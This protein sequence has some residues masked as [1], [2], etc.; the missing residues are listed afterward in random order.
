MKLRQKSPEVFLAEGPIS[1]IGRD[2]IEVLRAA[3]GATQKRR[4]RIN[5][6]PDSSDALHEMMIAIEP[7]SYI[8][9]HKHPAKSESFHIIEGEVDIIVLD[10][11]GDIR[12]IVSL[13]DKDSGKAFYYRMSQPFFHTLIIRS[14]LLIMHEITN[15][16]FRPEGTVFADFAPPDTDE[17]AASAYMALLHE[18]AAAFETSDT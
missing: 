4:A 8:R 11:T 17:A 9:P 14:P 1:E 6:H 10:D 3:V 5:A 18:R 13:G 2:E 15:G 7:G 16:P 12:R